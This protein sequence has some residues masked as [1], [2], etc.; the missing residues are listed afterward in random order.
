MNATQNHQRGFTLLE[1]IGVM[2][3][4]AILAG[5]LAPQ[6]FRMIN[7]GYRAAEAKSLGSIRDALYAYIQ[8][9]QQV[10][11]PTVANWT[12]AVAQFAALPPD[13][14]R[15]NERNFQ[16]RLYADPNFFTTANTNFTGYTQ[17][18]GLAAP[19]FSPRLMVVSN[20]GSNVTPN[21]NTGAAFEA[22]WSQTGTPALVESPDLFIERIHL[23]SLFNRVLLT[24]EASSQVGYRLESG[25]EGAIAA[26]AGGVDGSRTLYALSGSR[27]SLTAAP[28]PGGTTLRQLIVERQLSL[29]YDDSSG[30][31]SWEG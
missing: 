18:S 29:R 21:L 9:T 15:L 27:L 7:E 28:F 1:M 22:V 3:V 31:Y 4:M 5:A 26:A 14:V 20:L 23:A 25:P 24:N 2:A 10:P 13:R 19:P 12:T 30:S 11:S 17:T 16:R 8:T 6:V